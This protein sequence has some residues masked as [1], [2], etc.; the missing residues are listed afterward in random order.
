M[1]QKPIDGHYDPQGKLR[2][3]GGLVQV[4]IMV[5]ILGI[6][7]I[8]MFSGVSLALLLYL[9]QLYPVS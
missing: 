4:L 6:S 5:M 9:E 2:L 7:I 1:E 3:L 8:K